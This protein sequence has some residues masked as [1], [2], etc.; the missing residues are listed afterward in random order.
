MRNAGTMMADVDHLV[1]P[2]AP[3]VAGRAGRRASKAARAARRSIA[4]HAA[5]V[6][7]P[8][9]GGRR[10]SDGHARASS[11]PPPQ[12][13]TQDQRRDR[14]PEPVMSRRGAAILLATAA[15]VFGACSSG[16]ASSAPSAAA[17]SAAQSA[18]PSAAPSTRRRPPPSRSTGTTSRTTTRARACGRS[19]PTSTWPPTRT[20]RST[21]PSSRTRRS[22]PSSPPLLQAG[23]AARPVPV[24]GRRRAARAG[25]GRPGQGHHRRRRVV[26]KDEINPGALG[27]YQVDGKQYGIPFDLGMVGFW[28]NKAQFA[29]GR[30]HRAARRP[31]TSSWPTSGSSRTPASPRSPWPARTSGPGAFYWAYL[32]VRECGKAGMDKAVTTGDWSDPCFV[33]A[34]ADFK[35]LIDLKPFQEGFLAA[36]W[37]GAGSGA[38]AHG[39]GRW[40]DAAHGPVAAR[41]G[42]TPTPPTRRAWATNLGWFPF[43][44]VT[45]GAGDADRRFGGGN[46]FAVGKDAPPE[47]VDFLHFLVSKDAANRWGALNT[48]H[49]ADHRR[50]RV[51]GHRPAADGRA[52]RPRQGE[53]RPALSRPGH[54]AGARRV[55]QRCRRRPCT[56]GPGTP[57]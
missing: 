31:G 37:D 35:K 43:P 57:E 19:W 34:G 2:H 23:D 46:G 38:A 27:M 56:P 25:R 22:R 32:A 55:H 6:P 54:H 49:P 8:S 14:R 16:G 13:R 10:R 11:P 1:P 4:A 7:S 29:Q 26:G 39:D 53:V 20:S 44:A 5:R 24:V 3:P 45:G 12:V 28:Y 30:D 21:S 52:G 51:V 41:H 15:I 33:K 17:P 42:R 40:R 18:A 9:R 47:T 36:P 50:D 48:R